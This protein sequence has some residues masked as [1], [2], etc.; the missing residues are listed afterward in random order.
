MNVLTLM[1]AYTVIYILANG[2][3]NTQWVELPSALSM[4]IEGTST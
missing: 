2:D 4:N 1:C 3:T